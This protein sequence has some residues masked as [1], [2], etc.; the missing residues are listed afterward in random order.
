MIH[1]LLSVFFGALILQLNLSAQEFNVPQAY[2]VGVKAM[3]N[4]QY[5]IGLK[6]VDKVI[7]DY[8]RDGMQRFGPV[9]G[10]FYYLKGML[11]IKKKEY[12]KAIDSLKI[13]HDDFQN[14]RGGADMANRFRAESLVQ[15]GGCLMQLKD[16]KAAADRYRAAMAL[17]EQYDPKID[18]LETQVNLSKAL[19][20][21]GNPDQGK[22]YIA[23]RLEDRNLT[24]AMR[25]A[26]FLM[27]MNDWS[28]GAP[29]AEVNTYITKYKDFM[30]ADNPVVRYQR[31]NPVYNSLASQA[32]RK[33]DPDRALAWY[34]MMLD[35]IE[36]GKIYSKKIQELKTK[37]NA[38]QGKPGSTDIIKQAQVGIQKMEADMR[39][40][41]KQWAEILLGK[42]SAYYAKKN[43]SEA[44]A[45][46]ETLFTQ[47]PNHPE[48]PVIL[49]NLAACAVN[50]GQLEEAA[51]Y[52]MEFFRKY[53]KDELRPSMAK[54]LV[55]VLFVQKEYKEAH[56]VASQLAKSMSPKSKAREIPDFVTAASLYHLNRFTEAE[57]GLTD[58]FEDYDPRVR[59]EHAKF[60]LGATKVNLQKWEEASVVLDEFLDRYKETELRPSAL[61]FSALCHLVG[62]RYPLASSRV[63]ELQAKYP[64]DPQVPNSY[65]ILGDILSAREKPYTETTDAYKRALRMVEE[66]KRGDNNVAAYALRQLITMASNEEKW[67]IAAGYYDRFK[68]KYEDSNWRSDVVIASVLPLSKTGRKDEARD[69]LIDMVN[70]FAD[71]PNSPDLDQIFGS[72]ARFIQQQYP[73][74]E[75]R[76]NLRNFPAK[77]TP[78][79]PALQA[80]LYM[81]EIETLSAKD[82]KKYQKDISSA[83][84]KLNALYQKSG[85][86]LSNYTL[87][88]L[89]RYNSKNGG[90]EAQARKV[91]EYIL[92]ERPNGEAMGFALVDLGKLDAKKGTKESQAAAREL[93]QRVLN[94]V[95]DPSIHEDAVLGIARIESERENFSAAQ[96]WW[97]KY[98]STPAWRKAR[99]EASYQY[100]VCLLKNGKR[101]EA[102]AT[103]VNVY[104]NFPGQL[105]WSTKA[106]IE[107]AKII[108][109][110]GE[111]LDALKLLRE[112]IQRMGHLEHEGVAQGRKYFYSWREE[113]VSKQGK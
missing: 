3:E 6:A 92:K 14:T 75:V 9:F 109:A 56:R 37:I 69:L 65:N 82:K 44:K 104:S 102:A 106:Y 95:D 100:G 48:R 73:I 2:D 50:L 43:L 16:Y 85:T 61:Y 68:G 24:P 57:K 20:L 4:G 19:I 89:A 26:L 74:E 25:R 39:D 78:P 23:T 96:D 59:E 47:F 62:E 41:R 12:K 8:G 1:R 5:D 22:S 98:R 49:H 111:E 94:E 15:W 70:E 32:L 86:A 34:G 66:E 33:D 28:P 52:G 17:P 21:S 64:A 101:D 10:H 60:Y 77:T 91:Y 83:F 107:T 42:A 99:A 63:I 55:E 110:K 18:K 53:P 72:Y 38:I 112:M 30:A 84:T 113:Y 7:A 108:R 79:P 87:V 71:Q 31:Q 97:K 58:Y 81:A 88:Q 46:Y 45:A 80:W 76:E 105:D 54:L 93:F 36:A 51:K 27:L 35:P 90:N 40:Q 29:F 67:E 11:L 13:C 103:F